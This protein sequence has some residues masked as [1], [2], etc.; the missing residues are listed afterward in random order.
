MTAAGLSTVAL[1]SSLLLSAVAALAGLAARSR[2][3]RAVHHAAMIASGAIGLA[4]AAMFLVWRLPRV[5]FGGSALLFF[6]PL[7]VD[8]LSA[9]FLLLVHAVALMA[10]WFA[11]AYTEPAGQDAHAAAPARLVLPLTAVFVLSM[12]AVVLSSGVASFLLFWEAMSLAAF[13]LVMA[14]REGES[15]RAALLYLAIAQ[16]GAG[17]LIVGCGIVGRGSIFAT[18][19]TLATTVGLLSPAA[20]AT[21]AALVIFAFASKAGLAP[22]HA[23]LPEAHPRAPSHVSALMSGAM[24]KVALYGLIR[25][26]SVC[27][28]SLPPA[29]GIGLL[30]LG[31]AGAAVAA[32]YANIAREI[33]R[34][35]AW[36]SVENIGL[37]FVMFGFRLV[38]VA[39]GWRT[40]ADAVMAALFLHLLAHALFKAGLFLTAG[41]VMHG[42][43]TGK[44]EALGGLANR[45][46]R[47]SA[48]ALLLILAASALPPFGS[49][50]AEW[51]LV[52]AL[53]GS[54]ATRRA[55]VVVTGGIVLTG[56]AFVAGL[57]V[58]AMVRLFSFVFLAEPRSAAARAAVE[59]APGL[60]HPVMAL[61]LGVLWLGLLVPWLAPLFPGPFAIVVR[62]DAGTWAPAGS[63]GLLTMSGLGVAIAVALAGAWAVRRM[64]AGRGAVRR[65]HTWDCGQPI[66]ESMEYTATGF[67]AP[68]RFFLR[69]I[70]RAEKHLVFRPVTP[71]NPWIRQGRMEFRKAGGIL[72]R[73]YFPVA[74]LIEAVGDRLRRLQNGVIQFY[75][76]L[77]LATLLVTLWVA[78]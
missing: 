42:T 71:T 30:A 66:D 4:G 72:A 73:L 6:A 62:T 48:A 27:W 9:F 52:Q 41:A 7:V 31:L 24:L 44:I 78:L 56:L 2:R 60:W 23:W 36:S 35:L 1:V 11:V 65:Y 64:L 29:W 17:A 13:L 20:S 74:E 43:H 16:F 58:F 55:D 28:P 10:S 8:R 33:K 51:M 50:A 3:G 19:D 25:F 5:S 15:L 22:F 47:P 54:L 67:S 12:Q 32:I 57:A 68:V 75:I 61:A 34:I 76:A 40:L 59:P 14:D 63:Q 38:L 26:T 49:F 39:E 53:L 77:I 18:F 45:M 46:P 70:V 37:A 21:A 69:D